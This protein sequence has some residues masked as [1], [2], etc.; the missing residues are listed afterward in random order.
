MGGTDAEAG[1]EESESRSST[2][3]TFKLFESRPKTHEATES[4]NSQKSEVTATKKDM[5][6]RTDG[7]VQDPR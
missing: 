7:A 4:K 2:E 3:E 5:P 6:G 1:G